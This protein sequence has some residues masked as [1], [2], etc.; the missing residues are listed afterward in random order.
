MTTK[1]IVYIAL[2]AS[3]IAALGV[4][5]PISLA[6]YPVPITSQSLGVMISGSILGSKR[7]A[8]S[9][10]LFLIIVVVG[11]PILAGG[12]GGIGVILGPSG[13]FL[14]CWPITAYVIGLLFE[15]N[16]QKLNNI[17]AFIYIIF[18][19]IIVLYTIGILWLNILYGIDM[20]KGLYGSIIF[21][22]GDIIKAIIATTVSMIIKKSYP[23]IKG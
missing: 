16:W 18:G 12:R 21:I 2:F 6:L 19:G 13:G 7:G 22:F 23:L 4:V 17:R 5:P 11:F 9:C 14:L 10:I 3:I 8:L 1:D 15:K 20:D